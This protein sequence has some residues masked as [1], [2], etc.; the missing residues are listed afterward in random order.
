MDTI[1][2]EDEML[3]QYDRYCMTFTHKWLRSH[4]FTDYTR[5][6]DDALQCARLGLLL[7]LRQYNIQRAEDVFTRDHTPYWSMYKQLSDG[8][9][10]KTCAPCGVH[11]PHGEIAHV[12]F[13]SVSLDE[14]STDDHLTTMNTDNALSEMTATAFIASLQETDRQ[15][16]LMLLDG[17]KP[18]QIQKWLGMPPS[19]YS[20][21]LKRIRKQWDKIEYQI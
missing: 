11:R 7:Y 21:R 8:V 19:T 14:A 18:G 13:K 5:I 4:N 6:W 3:R 17:M 1:F 9:F 10:M 20:Y 16:V 12:R 2:F 15:L